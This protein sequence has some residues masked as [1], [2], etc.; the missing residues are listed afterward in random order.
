MGLAAADEKRSRCS[1]ES[2]TKAAAAERM[3]SIEDGLP[4]LDKVTMGDTYGVT[5]AVQVNF[6]TQYGKE[7]RG[8]IPDASD[9]DDPSHTVV[10][11]NEHVYHTDMVQKI[12]AQINQFL[13][14]LILLH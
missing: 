1:E 3:S 6:V 12:V 4:I 8:H 2:V 9:P 10:P 13:D 7:F 5:C 11:G 14:A